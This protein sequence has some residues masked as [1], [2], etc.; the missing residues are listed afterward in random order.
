MNGQENKK[1]FFLITKMEKAFLSITQSPKTIKR[2]DLTDYTIFSV[3][4]L[5]AS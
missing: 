2:K 4:F 3:I 5:H 1:I